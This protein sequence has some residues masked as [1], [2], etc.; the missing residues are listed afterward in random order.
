MTDYIGDWGR[1][2]LSEA[3]IGRIDAAVAQVNHPPKSV[4]WNTQT[5]LATV[6]FDEFILTVQSDGRIQHE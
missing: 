5:G 6:V 3:Q 4:A 2:V 1:R